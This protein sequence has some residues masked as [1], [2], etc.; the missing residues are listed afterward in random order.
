LPPSHSIK[1]IEQK[2]QIFSVS[3]GSIW[4]SAQYFSISQVKKVLL[5]DRYG[6]LS[7]CLLIIPSGSVEFH[8][9]F[10]DIGKEISTDERGVYE[11]IVDRR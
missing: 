8:P 11:G 3:T 7:Q 4:I 9:F 5:F 1:N 10:V 2:T 6:C